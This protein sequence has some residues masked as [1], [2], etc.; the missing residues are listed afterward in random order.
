MPAV[1]AGRRREPQTQKVFVSGPPAACIQRWS[2]A[3]GS[4]SQRSAFQWLA[5][6]PTTIRRSSVECGVWVASGGVISAD[7]TA[8]CLSFAETISTMMPRISS[9]SGEVG[10]TNSS[11]TGSPS[12]RAMS[13]QA[14]VSAASQIVRQ[15]WAARPVMSER[16][17]AAWAGLARWGSSTRPKSTSAAAS[18]CRAAAAAETSAS[19]AAVAIGSATAVGAASSLGSGRSIAGSNAKTMSAT[20]STSSSGHRGT[21]LLRR[22]PTRGTDQRPEPI[23]G[24]G[25]QE[26]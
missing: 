3:I 9:E 10:V 13:A 4:S 7:E 8:A 12:I 26:R 14:V 11:P 20:A 21:V 24:K 18:A 1:A 19:V 17:M 2:V 15:P 25:T 22:R 6:Q 16:S 23:R 5:S